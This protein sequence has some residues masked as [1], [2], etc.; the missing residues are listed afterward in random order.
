MAAVQVDVSD[1]PLLSQKHLFSETERGL[2]RRPLSLMNPTIREAK[3]ERVFWN[4]AADRSCH[5][6][7]LGVGALAYVHMPVS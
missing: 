1:G 6:L 5:S 7:L 4:R 2:A 3:V